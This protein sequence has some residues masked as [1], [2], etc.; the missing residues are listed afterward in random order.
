MEFR[1][2]LKEDGLYFLDQAL[3]GI[4]AINIGALTEGRK[5]PD[6]LRNAVVSQDRAFTP[7]TRGLFDTEDDYAANVDQARKI[8]Q[9]SS[10]KRPEWSGF[11]LPQLARMIKKF[12]HC[13]HMLVRV[14]I[15][16]LKC[17]FSAHYLPMLILQNIGT[18]SLL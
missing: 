1:S 6:R 11:Q 9:I 7:P 8:H 13:R 10:G 15:I 16:L 18:I 12:E 17:C 3:A 4:V 14:Q 5:E 2:W